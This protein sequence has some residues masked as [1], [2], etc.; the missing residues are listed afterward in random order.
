MTVQPGPSVPRRRPRRL[1]RPRPRPLNTDD[2]AA[3]WAA[4]RDSSPEQHGTRPRRVLRLE[5]VLHA[6]LIEGDDSDGRA[7]VPAPSPTPR[8]PQPLGATV[9]TDAPSSHSSDFRCGFRTASSERTHRTYVGN[10]IHPDLTT[11]N[12][13][14][15]KEVALS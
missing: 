4:A 14:N 13:L 15:L 10:D 3:Y 2:V 9:H 6:Y 7:P 5:F 12:P 8:P 11:P 1:D